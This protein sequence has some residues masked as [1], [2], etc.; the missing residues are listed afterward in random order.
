MTIM[1][2]SGKGRLIVTSAKLGSLFGDMM[3]SYRFYTAEDS[4][5]LTGITVGLILYL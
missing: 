3:K 4:D 5:V 2:K 1:Q